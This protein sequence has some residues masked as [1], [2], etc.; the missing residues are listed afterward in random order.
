MAGETIAEVPT[1]NSTESGQAHGR[2]QRARVAGKRAAAR[3]QRMPTVKTLLSSVERENRSGAALLAG[4]LAYR[5]FFWLVA[6]GLLVAAV[7]SFWVRSSEGSLVDAAKSFGLSGVAARSAA[8]AVRSESHAR[9]Y[10]LGAGLILIGYFGVG[11]VRAVR[12]SAF[13][14]WRVPPVRLRRRVR[15]SGL[16]AGLFL[17]GIGML[18]LTAWVR[19]HS[20]A[21]GLLAGCGAVLVFVALAVAA[22]SLLPRADGTTWRSLV[23]GGLLVGGGVTAAHLFVVYYLAGKLERSPKLYGTLGAATVVLLGLYVIA[24]VVVSAMFLNATLHERRERVAQ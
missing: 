5:L 20:V 9:W 4:G 21:F 16:F 18:T 1:I 3:A 13:I 14:A 8:A 7:A 11:V 23:P 24:R 17:I 22:F 2:V 10:F 19:E 12:V 15:A 6:F